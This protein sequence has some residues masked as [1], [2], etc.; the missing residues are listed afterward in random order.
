MSNAENFAEIVKYPKMVAACL[1]V[2][3]FLSV[4]LF[5]VL[6]FSAWAFGYLILQLTGMTWAGVVAGI[7][8]AI[9]GLYF[10]FLRLVK[11]S[12]R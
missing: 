11:E 12:Q 4:V 2:G 10:C 6:G 3:F 9:V 1:A 8:W 7:I 5:V